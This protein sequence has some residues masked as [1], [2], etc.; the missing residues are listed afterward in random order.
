MATGRVY[1]V[2][3]AKGGVGK[4][5]TSLNLGAA[6]AAAGRSVVVVELDLAMANFADFL[7]LDVDPETDTTVHDVLAGDAAV[8]DA[9][10]D[11]PG[12]F[13][14]VPSGTTLDGFAKTDVDGVGDVLLTL[15]EEYEVVLLDT[16]A[17]LSHETLLPLALADE[18]LLV[19]SPRVASVRDAEKTKQLAARVGG[20]VA[21]V[22][23]VRSGTGNSPPVDRIAD[24]LDVPMFGHVPEDESVPASQDAGRPV[25]AEAPD[26]EAAAAYVAIAGR[27]ARRDAVAADR[28]ELA[29][30]AVR[31]RQETARHRGG[32]VFPEGESPEAGDTDTAAATATATATS[33]TDDPDSAGD[34]TD[35]SDSTGGETDA[36]DSVEDETDTREPDERPASAAD[37]GS[38]Q[39]DEPT[40]SDDSTQSNETAQANETARPDQSAPSPT[41]VQSSDGTGGKG[42]PSDGTG[43]KGEPS[44]ETDRNT[45]DGGLRTRVGAVLQSVRQS[46]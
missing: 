16:G 18:T 19:S 24:F 41:A 35:G 29:S 25:V 13:S 11:A 34:E 33:E 2:A 31:V 45:A 4:T 28:G 26:S 44:D 14:V 17:G 43:G 7:A 38:T 39:P 12:G 27:L 21:G 20:T 5:T 22:V 1:A 46:F 40:Q 32:F 23:F 6:L 30:N 9:V 8:A 10:Y 36:P 3:G 37:T 15:R 42:E